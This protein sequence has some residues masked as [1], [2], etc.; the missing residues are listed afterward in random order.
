MYGT[1]E[2]VVYNIKWYM[3][4]TY[5][6]YLLWLGKIANFKPPYHPE[7]LSLVNSHH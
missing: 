2:E 7:E 1:A 6:M 5:Y 4:D 3:A